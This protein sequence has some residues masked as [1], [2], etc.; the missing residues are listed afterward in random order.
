MRS[1][2]ANADSSGTQHCQQTNKQGKITFG[3]QRV[4]RSARHD[5]LFNAEFEIRPV[6]NQW[7]S[8]AGN[9]ARAHLTANE[10]YCLGYGPT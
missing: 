6:L 4:W 7:H 8:V 1:L 5:E 2:L 3:Q 9:L 10:S